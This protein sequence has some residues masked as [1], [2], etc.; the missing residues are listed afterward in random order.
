[1]KQAVL[2]SCAV[3]EDV[4]PKLD[5]V[6]NIPLLLPRNEMG[7]LALGVEYLWALTF[8]LRICI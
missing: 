6:I 7:K 5:G 3:D 4:M 8:F 1:M 2:L